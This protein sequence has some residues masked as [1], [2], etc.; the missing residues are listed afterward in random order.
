VALLLFSCCLSILAGTSL[1]GWFNRP[2][3][4][5]QQ[6]VQQ[7]E[8]VS[9]TE[10]EDI[11]K[12][13]KAVEVVTELHNHKYWTTETEEERWPNLA[14]FDIV[15]CHTDPNSEGNASVT[16]LVGNINREDLSN[17]D[18]PYLN[19]YSG[20]FNKAAQ[21]LIVS[22]IEDSVRPHVP[23]YTITEIIVLKIN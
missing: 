21:E 13:P 11:V 15:T 12:D 1:L 4:E 7:P 17:C 8:F 2:V 22:E 10:D 18:G 20:T 3:A 5:K 6:E 16:I 14:S 19:G 23:G 9:G